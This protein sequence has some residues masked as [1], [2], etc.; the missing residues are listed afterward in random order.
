[1]DRISTEIAGRTRAHLDSAIRRNLGINV[2]TV[3]RMS[4]KLAPAIKVPKT[5]DFAH[6]D[7]SDRHAPEH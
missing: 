7:F 5:I 1:M 4:V 6:D 2:A 3:Q